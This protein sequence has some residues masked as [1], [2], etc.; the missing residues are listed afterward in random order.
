MSVARAHGEPPQPGVP[1][2]GVTERADVPPREE[3]LI[4]EGILGAIDVAKD[5][6]GNATAFLCSDLASGI[7]GETT[8]VDAGVNIMG[9]VFEED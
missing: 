3:E 1:G 5:E 8:F 7:T 2:I 4:L 9:M 6:V